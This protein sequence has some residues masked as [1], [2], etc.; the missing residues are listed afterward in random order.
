VRASDST[1]PTDE[2]EYVHQWGLWH[3]AYEDRRARPLG[4]T[5]EP[6]TI[7]G[8][9]ARRTAAHFGLRYNYGSR[10]LRQADRIPAVFDSLIAPSEVFA[11]LESH[12]VDEALVNH[13]PKG[14]SIGWHS[15]ADVYKTIIGISLGASCAIQFR[16]RATLD[17][18]VFELRLAPR[19]IYV[20]GGPVQGLWQHR[21]PE[22]DG[23]RYSLI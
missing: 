4:F 8:N 15:D 3:R 18:R 22:T 19:S 17:R 2:R 14:A 13:Y 20:M 23:E 1:N 7:R 5:L 6:I 12:S 16:T 9:T 21:I 11:G 10:E